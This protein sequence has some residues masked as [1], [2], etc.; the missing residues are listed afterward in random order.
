VFENESCSS[1][2]ESCNESFKFFFE[3]LVSFYP[4]HFNV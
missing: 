2:N 3:A 1:W 4:V